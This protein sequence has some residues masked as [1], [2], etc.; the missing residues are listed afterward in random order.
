MSLLGVPTNLDIVSFYYVF[1]K[2]NTLELEF[3][4]L[5]RKTLWNWNS[6]VCTSHRN[7][8]L[9]L[10]ISFNVFLKLQHFLREL[11]SNKLI[12]D[13]EQY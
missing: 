9:K 12:S 7:C 4:C 10:L 5:Y 6:S 11:F 1:D 2:E 13:P 3:Q 8:L